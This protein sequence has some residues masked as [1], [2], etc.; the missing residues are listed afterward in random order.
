MRILHSKWSFCFLYLFLGIGLSSAKAS[1]VDSLWYEYHSLGDNAA[2]IE[3]LVQISFLQFHDADSVNYCLQ[4]ADSLNQIVGSDI[5]AG[6]ISE[7]YGILFGWYLD[8]FGL[9]KVCFEES[10]DHFQNAKDEGSLAY[11]YDGLGSMLAEK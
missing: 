5:L 3:T 1:L 4:K 10:I 6:R 8:D 11:A 9:A 2:K 7:A